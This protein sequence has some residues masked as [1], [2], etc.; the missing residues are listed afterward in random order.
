M[1][2]TSQR[3]LIIPD[4]HQDVFWADLILQKEA[5]QV[6]RI[7]FLGDYYDSHKAEEEI[8]TARETAA[9]LRSAKEQFQDRVIFLVGNHDLPYLEGAP[10]FARG[11]ED[12]SPAYP[13]SGFNPAKGVDIFREWDLS[14]LEN[15][16]LMTRAHGFLLSHAGVA[17]EFWP[18][19]TSAEKSLRQLEEN[20]QSAWENFRDQH[21]PILSAG[22][23]RGGLQ[24]TGGLLWLDW[25]EEFSDDL[26]YPQIVGH[27]VSTRSTKVRRKGRSYCLD[28][29][30]STYGILTAEG[31]INKLP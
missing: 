28:N 30:Q 6:G 11:Q 8:A 29:S 21:E 19:S 2:K 17:G 31:L 14:W 23:S 26:P 27:T 10:L 24:P 25:N 4:M 9:F 20:C 16:S 3:H 7:I 18:D 1:N 13:C 12:F 22:F 5:D 15:F